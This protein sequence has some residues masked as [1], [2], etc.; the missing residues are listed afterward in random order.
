MVKIS[1][2]ELK[3][4]QSLSLDVKIEW[5]KEV[6]RRFYEHYNGNVRVSFSGGRDSTVVLHLA[7]SIYPNIAA[8]CVDA[9]LWP[10]IR[11]FV[12]S[13]PNTHIIRPRKSF[14]QVIDDYGYPVVSKRISQY[15]HEA[16]TTKS[17]K[18]RRLRLTGSYE[19]GG[20]KQ[21]FYCIS[22]KWKILLDAPFKV[23]DRCCY[24]LKKSPLDRTDK[25]F[26]YP[27]L[28]N[29]AAECEQRIQTYMQYG[30]NALD[31]KRPHST[32][33]AFWRDDDVLDYIQALN[34]PYSPLYDM[35]YTRS[36]CF[37]CMF[38]VN[39]E[40]EPN[41][42]QMMQETHPKLWKACEAWGIPEVLDYIGVPYRRTQ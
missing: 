18:L 37:G 32:P 22:E 19:P 38:G 28:G 27:F 6:M 15:V 16:R 30:C 11:Q 10:E 14:A 1:R 42:F 24:W 5:S 25:E 2:E 4:R 33:I 40:D 31:L 7:R 35:G 20:K 36:G 12:K 29:R 3:A 23:S 26:G 34:V 9:L 41:R 8:V 17:E 39:Q 21:S 13:I